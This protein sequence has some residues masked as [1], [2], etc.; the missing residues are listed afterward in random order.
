MTSHRAERKARSQGR[1]L[2]EPRGSDMP[3]RGE[4]PGEREIAN[5]RDDD[6]LASVRLERSVRASAAASLDEGEFVRRL[7]QAGVL[8]RP[9]FTANRRPPTGSPVT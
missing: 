7:H 1:Q 5:R 2:I 6:T 3:M 9:R 4:R 8:V